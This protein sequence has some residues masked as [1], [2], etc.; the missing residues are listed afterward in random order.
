M[1]S[2]KVKTIKIVG[3]T[4]NGQ[5]STTNSNSNISDEKKI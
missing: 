2:I 3:Y 1:F 4:T 5:I